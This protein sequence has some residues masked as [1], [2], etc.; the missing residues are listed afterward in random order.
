MTSEITP[1][2]APANRFL[3]M[4]GEVVLGVEA[5]AFEAQLDSVR[6]ETGVDDDSML[7]GDDMQEIVKRFKN[8]IASSNVEVPS[9]PAKQLELAFAKVRMSRAS[10]RREP[11]LTRAHARVRACVRLLCLLR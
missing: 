1:P 11:A 9:D 2:L 7:T 3:A 10:T 8:V 6:E 4:F 5:A